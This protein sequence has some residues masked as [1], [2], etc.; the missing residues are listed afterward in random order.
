MTTRVTTLLG[1]A[2][3]GGD[4]KERGAVLVLG[5]AVLLVLMG[6]AAFSIDLGW[7]YFNQSKTQK[8][9]EA[10]ALA[11]VV[12]MPKPSTVPFGASE[13]YQTAV[14]VASRHGYVTDGNTT[15]Q[16]IQ[17]VAADNRLK[18]EIRTNVNTF[19][20]RLF[21]RDTLP[22]RQDATAEQLPPLKLGSDESYL[23]SD[24]DRGLDRFFWVAVNGETEAKQNGDPYSTRCIAANCGAGTPNPEYQRP[25]YYYA[26]EVPDS[27]IGK[28]LTVQVYD[29]AHN[30]TTGKVASDAGD[31]RATGDRGTQTQALSFRLKAPDQTPNDPTTP[32]SPIPG[33][34]RTYTDQPVTSGELQAWTSICSV[35]A[36]KGIYVLEVEMDGDKTNISDFSLRALTNGDPANP[37]AVYGIG[38]MSLDM[39]DSGTAPSFKIVKL[40]DYYKGNN[41]IL[42]LFDPGDATGGNA[43]LTFLGELAGIDCEVRITRENGTVEGWRPDDSPGGPPCYL[44]TSNQKYNEDWVE[45]RFKVPDGYTCASDCWVLVDYDFAGSV[46]T[47]RTTW[48]ARVD[49][50]PI[51]LVP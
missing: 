8:A 12:H 17:I 35:T 50:Q 5:A 30:F 1:L 13:A 44:E 42:S 40:E 34:T 22:I 36:V 29:G 26:I 38:A 21:G 43:D 19:F 10:A 28:T 33:C 37:T 20:M 11:G 48:A 7:Y 18:V 14:D 3:E 39:V 6:M 32:V 51:H 23:G 25:N 15:V 45:F 24:P 31:P 47:E 16:P 9:A 46:P 41:L 2:E 49:G 4:Q 27:E